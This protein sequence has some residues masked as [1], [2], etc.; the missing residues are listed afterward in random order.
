MSSSDLNI[1][2]EARR[3]EDLVT[4]LFR[5]VDL[6][7]RGVCEEPVWLARHCWTCGLDSHCQGLHW[8]QALVCV[9]RKSHQHFI[10]QQDLVL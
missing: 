10:T 9:W 4:V 8:V 6:E 5:S 3:L 1:R 7:L 2:E